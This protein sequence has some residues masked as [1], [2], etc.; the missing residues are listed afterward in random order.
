MEK[1]LQIKLEAQE[2]RWSPL[3]A[4]RSR[5][6]KQILPPKFLKGSFT[7]KVHSTISINIK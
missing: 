1:N 2:S 3:V 4:M 6:T 7:K 5:I